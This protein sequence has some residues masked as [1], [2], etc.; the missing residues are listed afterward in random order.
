[1]KRC[2]KAWFWVGLAWVTTAAVS[3]YVCELCHTQKTLLHVAPPQP[4]PFILPLFSVFS[5]S[6][7]MGNIDSG[8][9]WSI[10]QLLI[11]WTFNRF[12]LDLSDSVH[13]LVRLTGR[14]ASKTLAP[15]SGI[16]CSY[17]HTLLLCWFWGS[18]RRSFLTSTLLLS[19]LPS[20]IAIS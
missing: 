8:L 16:T 15:N 11:L 20:P 10:P 2:W 5:E 18:K 7:V 19:C 12:L 17:H 6:G 1:M 9:R 13:W 4:L 3:L 14:L